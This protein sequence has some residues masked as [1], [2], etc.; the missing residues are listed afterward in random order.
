MAKPDL[1][2]VNKEQADRA[3]PY[4]ECYDDSALEREWNE[5]INAMRSVRP[6]RRRSI[7]T[8]KLE[9]PG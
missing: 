4:S 9:R 5:R 6:N 1:K 8:K 7:T 3:L 2:I